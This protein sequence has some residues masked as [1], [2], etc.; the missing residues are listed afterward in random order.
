MQPQTRNEEGVPQQYP[1]GP[2]KSAR[3]GIPHESNDLDTGSNN[4]RRASS[5]SI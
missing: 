5:S 1:K 2:H 4:I 3:M